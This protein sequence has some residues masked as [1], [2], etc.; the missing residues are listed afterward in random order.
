MLAGI[1]ASIGCARRQRRGCGS[2]RSA[3]SG[4][5]LR[6]PPSRRA[7]RHRD[8]CP[9][10][11]RP[12]LWRGA[13]ELT[14]PA[15]QLA[16]INAS[17]S[18]YLGCNRAR[19]DRRRND[20]LLLRPRPAPAAFHRRDHLNFGLRHRAIPRINPMTSSSTPYAQGGLHRVDTLHWILGGLVRVPLFNK[21][22]RRQP[23]GPL[24]CDGNAVT[25]RNA[26][27]C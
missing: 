7:W 24:L 6:R 5:R 26:V 11:H 22:R 17:R 10:G 21:A 15:K 16:G 8:R 18:G 19:L 1:E 2:P 20:P 23:C 27:I 12:R 4:L 14:P 3:A 9:R 13:T 25:A